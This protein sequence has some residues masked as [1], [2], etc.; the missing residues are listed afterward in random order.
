MGQNKRRRT[1]VEAGFSVMLHKGEISAVAESRNLSLKG[2]LCGPVPGFAVDDE[3]EVVINLSEEAVI[4]ILSRVVRSDEDGLA[5]DFNSMDEQSFTF[6]H[7]LVQ[8]NSNDADTIDS[9][10]TSPAF[11]V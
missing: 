7:R 2:I 9:E 5:L 11:D 6:L 4:R 1:R 10:L 8:F 3:C